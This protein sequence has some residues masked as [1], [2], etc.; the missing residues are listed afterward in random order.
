MAA[1]P[2]RCRKELAKANA[3]M[4]L[5]SYSVN[6]NSRASNYRFFRESRKRISNKAKKASDVWDVRYILRRMKDSR[7]SVYSVGETVIIRFPFSR[8]SRVAPKR[9]YVIEGKII[10]RN[11]RLHKYK[12]EFI[13]PVTKKT[14]VRWLSVDD[15]TSVTVTEEKK[16]KDR[17]KRKRT[18][19]KRAKQAK[20]M[21][22]K[23]KYLIPMTREDNEKQFLEQGYRIIYNPAADGN[24]QFEA[25][26]F[27]LK[28]I[29]IH[30]S[31]C[32]L[33]DEIVRYLEENP[34]NEEGMPLE[35]YAAMP[36]TQYLAGMAQNSSFG[37]Q[38]TLQ[39]VANLFQI[40][41]IIVSSLGP[42]AQVTISPQNSVPT[43]RFTLGH[44]AEDEGIHY[45]CLQHLD[46]SV[47]ESVAQDN[48][49]MD[50][51]GATS[52]IRTEQRKYPKNVELSQ[53]PNEILNTIISFALTGTPSNIL[54]T[55]STLCQLGDPF[56]RLAARYS[57]RL[58]RVSY[59]RDTHAG[60]HSMRQICKYFGKNSGPC[61][62][63]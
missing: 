2:T 45:V 52:E 44:F 18:E 22:N 10:K 6:L 33:R 62:S 23:K 58:P 20:A 51:P 11:L 38:I 55:Y 61:I 26:A 37:D 4:K 17:A 57:R 63:T 31:N 49:N 54:K 56:K 19:V 14:C 34:D 32:S 48:N 42:E 1:P 8:T 53:L 7:P 43:A 3:T 35:M 25:L 29:G 59:N 30:R 28:N 9:R 50:P 40:E 60:Y 39:A 41:L 46:P 5:I 27:F 47:S 21:N 15:V 24:C 13:S 12:I 16:E 36:W